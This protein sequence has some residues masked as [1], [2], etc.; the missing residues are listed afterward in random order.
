MAT[1]SS[2]S[3][4]WKQFVDHKWS[5]K[6]CHRA[7]SQSRPLD[8]LVANVALA[9]PQTLLVRLADHVFHDAGSRGPWWPLRRR[10]E[11]LACVFLSYPE[12]GSG[13]FPN[14]AKVW[15]HDGG[16]LH[17]IGGHDYSEDCR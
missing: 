12:L 7:T 9:F 14:A 2:F 5:K 17:E 8:A 15:H 13:D 1:E 3:K 11:T 10:C 6:I 16:I 4:G